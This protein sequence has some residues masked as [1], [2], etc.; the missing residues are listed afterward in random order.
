MQHHGGEAAVY[1]PVLGRSTVAPNG[2]NG[3]LIHRRNARSVPA[4]A[5]VIVPRHTSPKTADAGP[6][7][8]GM[9]RMSS[10]LFSAASV[11]LER[12]G[13]VPPIRAVIPGSL[14]ERRR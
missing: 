11:S 2:G 14:V 10:A 13:P 12:T 5:A 6:V 1:A 7:V 8:K 4:K 3:S 9:S